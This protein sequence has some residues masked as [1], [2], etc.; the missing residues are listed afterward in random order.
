M[1]IWL[2]RLF[3]VLCCPAIVYF[4]ITRNVK[5]AALGLVVGLV[6][7]GFEMLMEEIS[8]LTMISGV[9]G[10]SGGI[11]VAKLVDYTVF[12]M[13]NDALYSA[14]D[15]YSALRYFAFATLGLL[16]AVLKSPAL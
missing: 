3:V 4:Q 6:I 8:L 9:L 16:I 14:W 10:T 5:G 1:S 2:F 13:G 12:Q 7:V 15:K 11:I